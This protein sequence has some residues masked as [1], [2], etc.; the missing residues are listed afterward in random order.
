VIDNEI[1]VQ[2]E[3]RMSRGIQSMVQYTHM[4]GNQQWLANQ[5]DQTPEWQL[6]PNI[7]PNRLVWSTVW[8]LPFG[9]GRQ[10][11]RQG[12]LEHVFGGWQLSWIYTYQTGPLIGWGNDYYYGSLDQVVSA[13]NQSQTHSQNIHKWYSPSAVWTGSG[14]PPSSFVGFEGRTSAQPNVY[15]ARIFPEYID[16]LRADSIR[17]WDTRILRRFTLYERLSLVTAL[18][19]LNMTNHTQFTAPNITVTSSSFGTLSGQANWP[20]ILQFNVRVEF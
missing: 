16:S 3:K 12:P 9:K 4:W 1:R 20:R 19:M 18:D 7:R 15:Q 8:E 5:F 14:A 2:Y 6:N 17:D 13:L 10:W 11:L